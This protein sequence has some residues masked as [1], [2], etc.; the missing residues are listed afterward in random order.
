[1]ASPGPGGEAVASETDPSTRQ[2]GFIGK[3]Q[4]EN[5]SRRIAWKST[6]IGLAGSFDM[7]QERGINPI[8]MPRK[9]GA[10]TA[11]LIWSLFAE[12][13]GLGNLEIAR[14]LSPDM[15]GRPEDATGGF[16]EL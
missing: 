6:P 10:L 13:P 9:S 11:A 5:S 4:K 2:S 3:L 8:D 15:K 1:L 16:D 7:D 14:T 12:I